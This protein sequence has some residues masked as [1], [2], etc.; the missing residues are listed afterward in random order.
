[1]EFW[2]SLPADFWVDVEEELV[3]ESSRFTHRIVSFHDH[4]E[5]PEGLDEIYERLVQANACVVKI[6]VTV[7]D[8][9]D[10]IAVWN[11]IG[12]NQ[13]YIPVAMGE[14]GKWTRILGLAH[15]AF[16]T[17]AALDDGGETAPGQLTA[18]EMLDVYRVK[19]LGL[20]TQVYGVIGDPVSESLSPY[21]HNAAFVETQT[22]AVFIPIRV[23]DLDQFVRRMVRREFREVELNLHGFA[24]TMPH[25]TTIMKHLDEIDSIAE[26]V[27]AVNT[28]KI[29]NDKLIGYNTDVQGFIEP[30][31]RCVGEVRGA[32]VAVIGTGGAARA[33]VYRLKAEGADVT[34]FAREEQKTRSLA[35]EFG[36]NAGQ[37]PPSV[38]QAFDIVVNSTP[39]G[40]T[41][42]L[43]NETLFTAEQLA[44]VKFVF[45]IVTRD[46]E[47]PLVREAKLAAIPAI[48]GLEMLLE[49]AMKQFEIWT[50]K[51]VDISVM[52]DAVVRS[53]GG[54][55]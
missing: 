7:E 51:T 16:M 48:G 26:Q 22:N 39:I 49:Q 47:T 53:R 54:S 30:L 6:A 1:V 20:E 8:A 25:K 4:N 15:G 38:S 34:V 55:A 52:R 5:V 3:A 37:W 41:G 42:A 29:E 46:D 28:V 40:M 10:A 27:G 35:G 24:V 17:Y 12:D 50:G 11:M 21:I 31:R 23:K 19:E 32:R 45:D 14:A 2:R 33:C 43:E 44:G 18:R 13:D 36:A 9:A